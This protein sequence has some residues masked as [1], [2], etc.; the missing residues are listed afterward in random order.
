MSKINSITIVGGGSSGWMTAAAICKQ[1]PNIKLTLIE[2]PTIPTIGVGEST[3][4]HIN[5]FLHFLGLTDSDWMKACNATYKTSIKFIDFRENP[6]K[7]PHVFHYP[8]GIF[9]YTNKPRGLM[10]WFAIKAT[11]PNID[12]YS[13]STF[14]H[15]SVMMT[16]AN[17]M[18]KNEDISIRGFNFELDTAYHMD[19]TLFG[20]YLRDII[21]LPSNMSH[22][23][24]MVTY[25]NLDETGSISKI[26]T[27]NSGE[28]LADLYI[29]CTGFKSL[30]LE[31]T[32]KVPFISFHDT[33]LN[34]SAVAAVIPYVDIEKEMECV[35]SCTAIEAGWIWNI[36]LWDRIGT[37]YVY[38]SK[39]ATEKEAE[40]QFL[41]HLS[42][43]RM[44][45]QDTD[46]L[47]DLKLRHIKIKHGVHERAWE[48][49]VIGIGLANGFIEPLE[50]TGLMLT[51]E[52]IIKVVNILKNRNGTVTKFDI[53]SFNFAFREQIVGFK[54]FISLHYALTMRNDTPYWKKVSENITYSQKMYDF[55]PSLS[56]GYTDLAYKNIR[57]RHY[58]GD[59]SGIV[60]IAAGM[61]YNPLDSS[62]VEFLNKR[63]NEDVDASL[64]AL[65]EWEKHKVEVLKVIDK[66]PTH[67]QF[68]K[69]TI[70]D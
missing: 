14:Y 68:L 59:M 29:D 35:T 17:K 67:Y 48:K 36:P 49:N 2:S 30:L 16:D 21:C 6:G 28:L 24:D 32:L 63:Y 10:E 54:D 70:Y 34:D 20:N 7:D 45:C 60:Y 57:S 18:T 46:R 13:F 47:K 51:H 23:L 40:E 69:D 38:S 58:G 50:S 8:F 53:D 66:L 39:Y 44:V 19:A 9:D 5:E 52:C 12:E 55:E 64:T 26:I 42:S 4:G 25:V 11:I 37:G 15:D 41:K 65:N 1:L 33:L 62:R 27:E 43:S 61:G 3:I 31:E 22:I 56:N